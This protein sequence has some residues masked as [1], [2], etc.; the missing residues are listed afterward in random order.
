MGK[1]YDYCNCDDTNYDKVK[2]FINS[3]EHQGCIVQEGE[4]RYIKI[5]QRR[6]SQYCFRK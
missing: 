3:L 4:L 6:Y 2:E 1:N 5:L